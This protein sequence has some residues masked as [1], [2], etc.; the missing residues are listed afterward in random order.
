M[1]SLIRHAIITA[2]GILG[3]CFCHGSKKSNA[4]Q[5]LVPHQAILLESELPRSEPEEITQ[6]CYQKLMMFRNKLRTSDAKQ[7][8][9]VNKQSNKYLQ[10]FILK[11]LIL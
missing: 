5:Q 8:H 7:N 11:M 3:R 6:T 9:K 2:N 4:H 1:M 10:R